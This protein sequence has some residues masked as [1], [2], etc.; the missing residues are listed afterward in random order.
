MSLNYLVFVFLCVHLSYVFSYILN[1]LKAGHFGP[2]IE[3]RMV[4][5]TVC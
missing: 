4:D 2:A 5:L 1:S 3:P